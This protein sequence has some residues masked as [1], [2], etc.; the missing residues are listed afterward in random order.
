MAAYGSQIRQG[1]TPAQALAYVNTL[2]HHVV[3]QDASGRAALQS[4]LAG[5]GDVVITYENEA[6]GAQK[7]GEPI[8]YV[9]PAQTIKIENPIAVVTK[10]GH[11]A[12]AQAFV[13]FLHS[14]TAQ[15][16]FAKQGYRPVVPG[17]RGASKFPD[18][19][20]I[21]TIDDLGGWST[22]SKRFF[23]PSTGLLAGIER[24]LGVATSK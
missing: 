14:T 1:R 5:R 4:F 22:V 11:V 15:A 16:I 6:I 19:P 8:D 13:N 7:K 18:P 20:S 2:F 21:F 17:V 9:I 24:G 10:G 12:R 3:A 23:D